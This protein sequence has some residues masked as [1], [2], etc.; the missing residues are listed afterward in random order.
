MSQACEYGVLD[1]AA[2]AADPFTC[3][4]YNGVYADQEGNRGLLIVAAVTAAFMCF[5]IGAND[6]ANA[7]G[8]TVG[9]GAIPLGLA[10]TLGGFGEW[11]GATLLGYG[12]SD[13]IK[14][15]VASTT[16]PACWACGY[17][18]SGMAVYA[19]GM[20]CALLAAA[21]FLLLATLAAM[22]VSTTHA[23]VAGVV[24]MTMVG[25]ADMDGIGCL[26]W[27]WKGGLTSIIAS[28]VISPVLSG[29]IAVFIYTTTK[30]ASLDTRRPGSN[31]LLLSPF[32][33]SIAAWIMTFLIMI[34]SKPTKHL[35]R[36]QQALTACV[37][38]G[39]THMYTSL[40]VPRVREAMPTVRAL[41]DEQEQSHKAVKELSARLVRLEA[42][43]KDLE[44]R[45]LSSKTYGAGLFGSTAAAAPTNGK[46]LARAWT[47]MTRGSMDGSVHSLGSIGSR[48]S[49]VDSIAAKHSSPGGNGLQTTEII[50][51]EMEACCEEVGESHEDAVHVFRYI[52]VFVAFLESFAHGANDTANS[53]SAFSAIY[54]A[55]SSDMAECEST[56]TPWWIMSI[57][58]AFVALG[59]MTLGYRVIKTLGTDIAEINYHMAFCVESASTCTVVIATC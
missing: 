27:A 40:L 1:C 28:W 39:A 4:P 10:V 9:S 8:A 21:I 58:G 2:A 34:K 59:V 46:T 37:V 32:L 20:L 47:A 23:I 17:C 50:P 5:T 52:V 22:P 42:S 38:A 3:S 54:T 49:L 41:R 7:W 26:N 51:E 18:H 19:V 11:L 45:Y 36:S 43:Y 25:S 16:D 6:S 48:S 31:A 55:F 57:A 14:K 44:E 24:G 33:Y 56:G 29:C 35:E 53:T 15:G 30:Y 12:V 13:T